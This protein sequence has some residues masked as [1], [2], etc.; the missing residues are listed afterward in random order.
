MVGIGY[1]ILYILNVF[2]NRW[3]NK[4]GYQLLEVQ[5]V[6][7]IWFVPFIPTLVYSFIILAFKVDK[8]IGKY[9]NFINWFNGS[10][11]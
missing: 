2:L 6:P 5:I 9:P 4:I 3:L 7:Q 8:F 1:F 11:W 10:K